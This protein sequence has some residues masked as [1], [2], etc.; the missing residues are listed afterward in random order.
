MK[1]LYNPETGMVLSYSEMKAK[2][3]HL[4]VIEIVDKSAI[5]HVYE[6][7]APAAPTRGFPVADN[8]EKEV[9]GEVVVEVAEAVGDVPEQP[10]I[11]KPAPK[12][13]APP[14]KKKVKSK[15]HVADAAIDAPDVVTE[16]DFDVDNL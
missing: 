6:G 10:A 8:K 2:M 9:A 5:N 7:L 14:K 15:A 13:K 4:Q 11:V 12:K 1:A 3:G 16:G